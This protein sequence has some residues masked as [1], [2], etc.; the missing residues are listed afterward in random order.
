MHYATNFESRLNAEGNYSH[1]PTLGIKYLYTNKIH[2]ISLIIQETGSVTQ[3]K[4]Q[5]IK[6]HIAPQFTVEE[7]VKVEHTSSCG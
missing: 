1:R 5:A 6:L 3:N 7:K 2:L 4:I